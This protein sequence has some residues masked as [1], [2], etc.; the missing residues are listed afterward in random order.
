MLYGIKYAKSVLWNVL[1]GNF[2]SLLCY[3]LKNFNPSKSACQAHIPL[4][5]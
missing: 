3:L 5:Y 1:T 4:P 2:F